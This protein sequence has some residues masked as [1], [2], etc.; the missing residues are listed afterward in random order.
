MYDRLS[1]R[2][3]SQA[4]SLRYYQL[5]FTTPGICPCSA[6]SRRAI[7]ERPN[8]RRYPRDRPDW[9]QRLRTRIGLASRGIFCSL[10]TASS[11]CSGVDLGLLMIFF[12]S[13]RRSAYRTD[14]SRR[15]SFL[16]TLLIFAINDLLPER[17]SQR[18]QKRPCLIVTLRG[19]DYGDVHPASFIDLVEIDLGKNELLSNSERVVA[20][21]VESFR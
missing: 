6:R 17:H 19:G 16:T 11:T 20:S 21:T 7:R 5:D 2:R 15:R 12:N 3:S 9:E 14:I 4:G 13:R 18:F 10:I 8:F 1:V